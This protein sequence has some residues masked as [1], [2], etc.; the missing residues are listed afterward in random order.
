LITTNPQ[1][2]VNG[3]VTKFFNTGNVSHELK[4]GFGYRHQFNDSASAWPDSQVIGSSS[5]YA[6]IT[7]GANT[8]HEQDWAYGF[9][10]DTLTA[11]NLTVSAGV[12]YDYQRGKNLQS[13]GLGN[14]MFPDILPSVSWPG[15][16]GFPF[17]FKNWEPRIS[18]TYAF[19]KNK[20]TLA[21]ASYSRFADQLSNVVFQLN[22]IPAAGGLYYYW[23]D[24]NGDKI[25]QPNEVDTPYGA[26]GT[27]LFDPRTF[28]NVPNQLASNFQ[29]PITDEFLI[30]ID[31]QIMDDFAVSVT[32]TYRKFTHL[33]YRIPS[34]SS[35]ST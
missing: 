15:D 30:G 22:A 14:Q 5:T 7:R 9:L 21:R 17:V 12:R 24:A 13:E 33:A 29:T 31:Q 25:F 8:R 16:T 32:G 35:L 3:N 10:G 4:F 34:G 11:G 26:T 19:G 23:N 28:P 27:Y 6:I 18:A 1:H 2:Q 20:T